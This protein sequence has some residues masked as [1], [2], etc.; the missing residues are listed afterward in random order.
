[1]AK[2]LI[3]FRADKRTE[4][5]IQDLV[6]WDNTT[7]TQA[8]ARA[9]ANYHKTRKTQMQQGWTPTERTNMNP[10]KNFEIIVNQMRYSTESAQLIASDVYWD[11]NNMERHGRNT[12][13][14][15]TPKGNF[16]A[17][18]LTQ[19]QGEHDSLEPISEGEAIQLYEGPLRVHEVPYEDAFP[20]VEIAEA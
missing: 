4:S 13:L 8:I 20:G 10:P 17:V 5:Q 14:Y 1:M 3:A 16:F 18:T 6:S 2:K 11:G 9:I 15:R 12:F 19:W 7:Q